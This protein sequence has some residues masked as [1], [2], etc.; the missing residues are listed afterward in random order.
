MNLNL[1]LTYEDAS[2][3]SESIVYPSA[4]FG[5]KWGNLLDL[6]NDNALSFGKLRLAYG[7]VGLA[8]DPHMWE[9]GYETSTYTSY[10]DPISLTA[11]GG[12]FRLND[13]QGN[14][15]LEFE[16]K[17]EYEVGLDLRFFRNRLS[18]S[19]TY[20]YNNTRYDLKH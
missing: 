2:S 11:F 18:L 10:S 16:K 4:E 15:A 8:P 14:P 19:G 3:S 13:D 12:G 1:G 20:Y 17:K 9:T 7:E 6:D 5:F